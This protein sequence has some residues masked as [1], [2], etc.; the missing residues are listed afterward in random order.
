MKG[1][2]NATD[3]VVIAGSGFG[4]WFGGKHQASA[5]WSDVSRVRAFRSSDGHGGGICI[6][7]TLKTG[8]EVLV[9]DAVPGYAGF[10]GAAEVALRGMVPR[11]TWTAELGESGSSASEM[12]LYERGRV[13]GERPG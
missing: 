13:R 7:L 11:A 4:V 10:I 9:H 3:R 5:R 12:V 2:P 1:D 6:G 8:A